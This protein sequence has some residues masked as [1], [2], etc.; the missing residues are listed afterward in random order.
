MY[1]EVNMYGEVI[2]PSHW[3]ERAET[4]DGGLMDETET[5]F[6]VLQEKRSFKLEI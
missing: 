6:T 2:K 5:P 4:N 1:V 3:S